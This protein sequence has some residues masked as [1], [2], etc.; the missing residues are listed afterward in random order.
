[1]S[2]KYIPDRGDL[3]WINFDPQTGKEDAKHRPAL[4]L[5]KKIY[6]Q[7]VGLCVLCP[8]TSKIKGYPFEVVVSSKEVEGAILADQ[9]KS[10]DWQAR[11]ARFIEKASQAT[12]SET[13]KKAGAMIA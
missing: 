1:M 5:S 8:I 7:K 11:E 4:V 10:L 12:L 3:I 6:N 13:Q 2:N 9:V